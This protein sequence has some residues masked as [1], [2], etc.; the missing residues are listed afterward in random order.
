[1][2]INCYKSG[3]LSFLVLPSCNHKDT[4]FRFPCHPLSIVIMA[5]QLVVFNWNCSLCYLTKRLYRVWQANFLFHMAFHIYYQDPGESLGRDNIMH[6]SQEFLCR[7]SLCYLLFHEA[8]P[9]S[10]CF[11]IYTHFCS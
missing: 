3:Y 7:L 2:Y 4:L 10:F 6:V 1:M 8:L 11:S 9:C 5:C